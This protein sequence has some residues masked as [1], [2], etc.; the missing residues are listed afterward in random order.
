MELSIGAK[1]VTHKL[2]AVPDINN[3][4]PELTLL[5]QAVMRLKEQ[6]ILSIP[7]LLGMTRF[8]SEI[9]R[10]TDKGGDIV[11]ARRLILMAY[12]HQ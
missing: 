10:P 8:Q 4:R 5:R 12:P 6:S 11:Q 1:N 2:G 9:C 7:L 3:N